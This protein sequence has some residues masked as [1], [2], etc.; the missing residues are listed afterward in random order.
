MAYAGVLTQETDDELREYGEAY[1]AASYIKYLESAGARVAP[2]RLLVPG[3]AVNLI[4]SGYA[5]ATKVFYDETISAAQREDMF[6]LWGT[7]LG[8]EELMTITASQNLLA[9][10]DSKNLS[11]PLEFNVDPATSRIFQHFPPDV[12]KALSTE[13][14]TANFHSWSLTLK[15]Y[16]ENSDLQQMYR[17]VSV[18]TDRNGIKFIST[19]EA[20]NY[21]IYA[22]QWHP[23]KAPFEWKE[24][25]AYSHL[26]SAVRASFYMADFFVNEGEKLSQIPNKSM[27]DAALIYQNIPVYTENTSG[28]TQAYFYGS[29]Y[30]SIKNNN[31]SD[32]PGM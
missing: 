22:V 11:L 23:E 13:D 29:S 12:I 26:S 31:Q 21:P 14:I 5:K 17:I 15:N 1:I 7:C 25:R 2:I 8:F 16:S 28:F 3:G 4:T 27:E 9:H 10:T 6:P 19:V 32:S 24:N 30:S 18:N 20:Y